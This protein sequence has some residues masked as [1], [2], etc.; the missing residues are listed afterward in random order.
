MKTK[1]LTI[2]LLLFTSQVFAGCRDDFDGSWTNIRNI[3]YNYVVRSKTDKTITLTRFI[4]WK[5]GGGDEY[6]HEEDVNIK[7]KPYGKISGSIY[8]GNLNLH[9]AGG[10]GFACRYTHLHNRIIDKFSD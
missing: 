3:T 4:I 2:C 5:K 6:M 8:V 10:I 9:Y 1:L 7:L